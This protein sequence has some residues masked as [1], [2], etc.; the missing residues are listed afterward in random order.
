MGTKKFGTG[1]V[2]FGSGTVRYGYNMTTRSEEVKYKIQSYLSDR[3]ELNLK[4]IKLPYLK[5][6]NP[7]AVNPGSLATKEG[8]ISSNI[9]EE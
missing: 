9:A 1:M 8:N 2:K 4:I 3:F 6:I 5:F 7:I